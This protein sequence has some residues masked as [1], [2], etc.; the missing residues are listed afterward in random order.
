FCSMLI[1]CVCPPLVMGIY[2]EWVPWVMG[3]M[4][5]YSIYK[6]LRYAPCNSKVNPI[7]D[8]GVLKAKR[9]GS[10]AELFTLSMLAVFHANEEFKVLV[11]IPLCVCAAL[12]KV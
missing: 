12:L 6:V 5:I 11:L 9:I 2:G 4:L 3:C 8:M 10:I 7:E 1:P